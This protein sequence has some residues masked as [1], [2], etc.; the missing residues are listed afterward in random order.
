MAV[1]VDDLGVEDVGDEAQGVRDRIR[2]ARRPAH[3]QP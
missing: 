3:R 2:L 1:E